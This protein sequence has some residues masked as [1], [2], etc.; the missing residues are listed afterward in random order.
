MDTGNS[1]SD[2]RDEHISQTAFARM[3]VGFT[4]CLRALNV[5]RRR[6]EW[7][8]RRRLREDVSDGEQENGKAGDG[9]IYFHVCDLR[10]EGEWFVILPRPVLPIEEH[11][12]RIS[13]DDVL[14]AAGTWNSFV[15]E[16]VASLSFLR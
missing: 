12:S 14:L 7:T 10:L 3:V 4:G 15:S 6:G 5:V 9:W 11:R 13:C 1:S 8:E 2:L 16:A